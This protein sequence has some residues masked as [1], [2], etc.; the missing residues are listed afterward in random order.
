MESIF[1]RDASDPIFAGLP[2]VIPLKE[3]HHWCVT[4]VPERFRVIGSSAVGEAEVIRHV[5]RFVYG[6]QSHPEASGELGAMILRNFLGL[7]GY[8]IP[9]IGS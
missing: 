6:F 9:A 8:E 4:S 1:V 7:C 3:K 2:A 5:D